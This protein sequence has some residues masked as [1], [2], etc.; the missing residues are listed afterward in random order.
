MNVR[1]ARYDVT[2]DGTNIHESLLPKSE[3]KTVDH[4]MPHYKSVVISVF[5]NSRLKQARIKR[6][7]LFAALAAQV[8]EAEHDAEAQAL[9]AANIGANMGTA[10]VALGAWAAVVSVAL[11]VIVAVIFR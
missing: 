1:L 3:P 2:F 9:V 8:D 5:D 6:N 7:F 4:A 11:V 10:T